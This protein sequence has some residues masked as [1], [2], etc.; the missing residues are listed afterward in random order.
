MLWHLFQFNMFA[1]IQTGGKQFL[2]KEGDKIKVETLGT[3]EGKKHVFE[4]V[5][6]LSTDDKALDLG[7]PFLNVKVE[8]KVLSHGRYDKVRT[9]KKKAKK[10][11]ERTQGHKQSYT[12]VEIVKIS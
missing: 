2:V 8:G 4:R 6:A 3:E 1:V 10:R 12:E 11:Y 7:T 5:L 9:V